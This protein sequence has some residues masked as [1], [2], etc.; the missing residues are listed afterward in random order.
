MK[1]PG[2]GWSPRREGG[3]GRGVRRLSARNVEGGLNIFLWGRNAHQE[4]VAPL[5]VTPPT[6]LQEFVVQIDR[7]DLWVSKAKGQANPGGEAKQFKTSLCQ[8]L[9][10]PSHGGDL[11]SKS[12]IHLRSQNCT[13]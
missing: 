3:E 6:P 2:G 12:A 5:S 11:Q 4:N 1:M 8:R 10:A 7:A 13:Q 9:N